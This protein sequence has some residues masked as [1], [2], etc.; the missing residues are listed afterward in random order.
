MS[1]QMCDDAEESGYIAYYRW[2]NANIGVY[3]C[4]KHLTEI[5]DALNYAQRELKPK[6]SNP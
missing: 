3:A 4:E 5:F 1:C 6:E 2:K